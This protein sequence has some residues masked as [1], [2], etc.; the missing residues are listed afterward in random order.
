V[1]VVPE[2]PNFSGENQFDE[3]MWPS[4]V[5]KNTNLF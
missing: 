5:H 2:N 4:R 1:G 3:K